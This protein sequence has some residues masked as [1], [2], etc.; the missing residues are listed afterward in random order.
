MQTTRISYTHPDPRRA[1]TTARLALCPVQVQGLPCRH[2]AG[3]SGQH[4]VRLEA[5]QSIVLRSV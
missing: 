2:A 1:A 4:S 3:H 5:G